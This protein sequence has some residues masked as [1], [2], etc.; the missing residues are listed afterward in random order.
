MES[1]NLHNVSGILSEFWLVINSNED[2]AIKT[3]NEFV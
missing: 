3:E 2:L 1:G